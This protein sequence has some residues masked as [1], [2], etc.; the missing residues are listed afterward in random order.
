VLKNVLL[1]HILP[2]LSLSDDFEAGP[3][4]TLLGEDVDV[5][6]DPLAFNQ[7]EALDETDIL[8]C[9]GAIIPIDDLLIPPGKT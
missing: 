1:Y 9:N 8:A 3:F 7:A 6:L 5:A 2:G 4:E